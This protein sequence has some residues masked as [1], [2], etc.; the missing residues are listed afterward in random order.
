ME[1]LALPGDGWPRAGAVCRGATVDDL[2]APGGAVARRRPR[3]EAGGRRVVGADT[4]DG[5][6]AVMPEGPPRVVEEQGRDV[7]ARELEI[8]WDRATGELRVLLREA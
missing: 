8:R 6:E 1:R 4:D 5:H 3:V 7:D 2:Q